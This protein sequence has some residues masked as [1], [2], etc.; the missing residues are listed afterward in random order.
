MLRQNYEEKEKIRG[1]EDSRGPS[2]VSVFDSEEVVSLDRVLTVLS[3]SRVGQ[4][5]DRQVGIDGVV[6]V[7]SLSVLPSLIELADVGDLQFWFILLQFLHHLLLSELDE[8][9]PESLH[10]PVLCVSGCWASDK[11]ESDPRLVRG[12]V[13]VLPGRRGRGGGVSLLSHWRSDG[14]AGHV[15]PGGEHQGGEI[16]LRAAVLRQ[17]GGVGNS[18]RGRRH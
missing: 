11:V 2:E 17:E 6:W 4:T 18:P 15:L 13:H 1:Q 5:G 8:D 7:K 10:D 9:L 16:C 12:D 3:L 14:G